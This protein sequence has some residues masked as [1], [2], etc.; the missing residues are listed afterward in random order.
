MEFKIFWCIFCMFYS[1]NNFIFYESHKIYFTFS[2]FIGIQ[3][4]YIDIEN[5]IVFKRVDSKYMHNNQIYTFYLLINFLLNV[6]P[7]DL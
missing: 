3:L 1:V 7:S 6:L 2:K 5:K 4:V